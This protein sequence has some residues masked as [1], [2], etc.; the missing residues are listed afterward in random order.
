MGDASI[1]PAST[2]EMLII[3]DCLLGLT[4]IYRGCDFVNGAQV[5]QQHD[6]VPAGRESFRRPVFTSYSITLPPQPA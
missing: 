2:S 5:F 4:R 1:A 3:W 6:F